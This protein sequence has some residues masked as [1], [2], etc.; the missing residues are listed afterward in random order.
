M[1]ELIL[2]YGELAWRLFQYRRPRYV[3]DFAFWVQCMM[4]GARVLRLPRPLAR[5]RRHEQQKSSD[6]VKAASEIRQIS[7]PVAGLIV[8]KVL[9]DSLAIQRLLIRSFVEGR[10][11]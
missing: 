11:T 10:T 2:K 7:S 4:A 3:A 5:F 9:P 1:T 8:P 6:W